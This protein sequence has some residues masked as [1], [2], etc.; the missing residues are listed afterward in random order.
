[1]N[2][3]NTNVKNISFYE[4]IIFYQG[5][6]YTDKDKIKGVYLH[7]KG[8]DSPEDSYFSP[9]DINDIDI[10]DLQY[11]NSGLILI[12]EF[13]HNIGH[14][15][16]DYMYPNWY[17]FF[18]YFENSPNLKF[19]YITKKPLDKI[20]GKDHLDLLEKF[21]GNNVLTINELKNINSPLCIPWLIAGTSQVGINCIKEDLTICREYM[22]HNSD[23]VEE[24]INRIYSNF[25]IRRNS[26]LEIKTLNVIFI[27]NKRTQLG[28]EVIINSLKKRYNNYNFIEIEWSEYSF[29]EQLEILNTSCLIIVGVGTARA[30]TPFLPNGAAEIQI[31]HYD[32]MNKKSYIQFFDYHLGTISKFIKVHNIPYYT[33]EECVNFKISSLLESYIDTA[34]GEIPYKTPIILQENIPLEVREYQKKIKNN[35]DLFYNWNKMQSNDFDNLKILFDIQE[36]KKEISNN[37]GKVIIVSLAKGEIYINE[38]NMLH[39]KALDVGNVDE[40]IKWTFDDLKKTDFY[41]NNR[42]IL[43]SD[44]GCGYWVWKPYIILEALKNLND[45]D[46]VI[47]YDGGREGYNYSELCFNKS[48]LPFIDYTYKNYDGFVPGVLMTNSNI[49]WCKRDCWILMGADKEEFKNKYQVCST[50]GIYRKGS[51]YT[52]IFLK[53]WLKYCLDERI[54]TDIPSTLDKESPE[55][56]EHRHDLSILSL[57]VHKYKIPIPHGFHP[58]INNKPFQG[59]RYIDYVAD[60]LLNPFENKFWNNNIIFDFNIYHSATIVPDYDKY[61]YDKLLKKL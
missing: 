33:E 51:F 30:N 3:N 6:F 60:V 13:H 16:W 14:L 5:D 25:N 43:D 22:N 48:I 50:W 58:N 40:S 55:F 52:E 19:T 23:P 21:S 2:K 37:I 57:L 10:S 39:K 49:Q 18:C 31:N 24:F 4:N 36:D 15:L 34:L 47:Y 35:M 29:K 12:N 32:P 8:K 45:N 28:S 44:R 26:L 59:I 27:K 1:M 56:I 46:C 38:M 54:I 53:K 42:K 7:N 11:L 20:T 17:S 41:N 9:L 61:S